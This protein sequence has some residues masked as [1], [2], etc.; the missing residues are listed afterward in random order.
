MS[1][2][3]QY[4]EDHYWNNMAT[5]RQSTKERLLTIRTSDAE[6]ELPVIIEQF[7]SDHTCSARRY[8]M[9]YFQNRSTVI[10]ALDQ[11][12][13]VHEDKS[14]L[15]SRVSNDRARTL[16]S[17]E[18][19]AYIRLICAIAA[20]NSGMTEKEWRPLARKAM[21]W[22]KQPE[23]LTREEAF[24]LGHG[25]HFSL[26]EMDEFLLRVSDNDGLSYARSEDVIEAFC[27]LYGPANNPQTALQL[28][29]QYKNAVQNIEKKKV[30]QKQ[31]GFTVA[32]EASLQSCIR[33]WQE[34]EAD[35]QQEFL[36]WL[37][38]QSPYLDIPSQSAKRVYCRLAQLAYEWTLD[39]TQIPEESAFSCAILDFCLQEEC[40]SVGENMAYRM[41]ELIL[42]TAAVEFDNLRKRQ[43]NQIWRYL[44]V[45]QKGSTT[46]IAIGNRIPQLLLGR[47]T[48]TKADVL[49]ML[50]YIGDLCWTESGTSGQIAY[51]RTVDFWSV[52]EK[53]LEA[54]NLP[55]FYAPHMLERCFLRAICAKSEAGEYPF[56]VYE[57][58][59]EYVLP[60][61]QER[62]RNKQG[63][64]I[65]KSRA[66]MEK[67]AVQAFTEE[68]ICFK[69]LEQQ[70]VEHF[71]KHG[72]E[73]GKYC[74]TKEGISY[75][76]DPRVITPFTDAD[77]AGMFD[78]GR[79][80]YMQAEI[81]EL[82]FRFVFGLGLYLQQE[83][84][85]FGIHCEFRT[86]YQKNATLTILRWEQL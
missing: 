31:K 18:R 42:S 1:N 86:N 81:A 82:R 69:G 35:V 13:Y 47:E 22:N 45:D 43:T 85:T 8:L 4:I 46:A 56:E 55:D 38:G 78:L 73:K 28:K 80:N 36:Q 20:E 54:A 53:L 17:D 33:K 6:S 66:Q 19:D 49:F 62:K 70:L 11:F 24:R 39:L 15:F 84:E 29:E 30:V 10:E 76:P 79:T 61:K 57:G 32:M 48:V 34:R 63:S 72:E 71:R 12:S 83:A 65:E 21:L 37:I 60:E 23:M 5:V 74:F 68:R 64:R 26:Q 75:L 14:Y 67:E 77:L 7:R 58:M 27:F 3:T 50:W 40:S 9:N 41:T 2:Y 52:S 51:D 59:C 25:L 44:T 16:D